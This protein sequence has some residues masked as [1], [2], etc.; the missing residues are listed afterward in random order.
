MPQSDPNLRDLIAEALMQWA[1]RNNSPQYA[2]MRRPETVKANAYSRA[3]AVLAVLT[4]PDQQATEA[5]Q[6]E[7]SAAPWA[8]DS[9]RIGRALIWSWSDIGK[10]EFGRGYRAAQEEARAIL[11]RVLAGEAQKGDTP[12]STAPL[13]AGL[14]QVQGNCPACG[15]ASL[16]LGS[17]GYVTCSIAECPEPDAASTVLERT[18]EAQQDRSQNGEPQVCGAREPEPRSGTSPCVLPA[19]HGGTKHQDK[20]TNQWPINLVVRKVQQD[21]APDGDDTLAAWL[22]Q[23]FFT[24]STTW[25]NADPDQQEYWE[26][27]ARAV[28]RAVARNGFK[29]HQ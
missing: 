10:G 4:T 27:Q 22:Y 13:A 12:A 11:T 24:G 7:P 9:A 21:P 20:W 8:T 18:R 17:G 29:E 14:P 1:E 16:F 19:G 15:H 6:D 5:Q 26:H 28:R 2:T 25:E 3:D 23:R